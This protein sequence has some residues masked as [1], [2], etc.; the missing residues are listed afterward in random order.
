MLVVFGLLLQGAVGTTLRAAISVPAMSTQA[1]VLPQ[2]VET[3]G[4]SVDYSHNEAVENSGR[5]TPQDCL[6][7]TCGGI[8]CQCPCHGVAAT[9][10][11]LPVVPLEPPM[12][13]DEPTEFPSGHSLG[14]HPPVRPPKI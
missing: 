9:L 8:T 12:V 5:T 3:A 11:I 2:S 7:G 6:N 1:S 10:A 4:P 13:I 14:R